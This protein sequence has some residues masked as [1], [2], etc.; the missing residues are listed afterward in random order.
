M[1]LLSL[2]QEVCHEIGIEPPTSIVNNEDDDARRLLT[3]FNTEGKRLMRRYDWQE[4]VTEA[5]F[6]TIADENQGILNTIVSEADVDRILPDTMYNRTDQRQREGAVG[7]ETWQMDKARNTNRLQW[8]FRVRGNSLLVN[9]VPAAGETMAFEYVSNKWAESSD[10]STKKASFTADS[11]NPRIDEDILKL[12]V[13][14]RLR[15]AI[16]A[17]FKPDMDEYMEQL[18]LRFQADQPAGLITMGDSLND[19]VGVIIARQA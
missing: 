15:A 17:E 2:A 16:G 8:Y 14:W 9:P 11:D 12:G 3:L 4:L 10:G 13:K 7:A 19:K 5:T 18:K 1:S 6:T